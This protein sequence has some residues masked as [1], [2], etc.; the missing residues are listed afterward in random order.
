VFDLVQV[1]VKMNPE[2]VRTNNG[3]GNLPIHLL[4]PGTDDG[5]K[6]QTFLLKEYPEESKIQNKSGELPVHWAVSRVFGVTAKLL[7]KEYPKGIKVE[8]ND[9]WLPIH[10]AWYTKNQREK[11]K[12][13]TMNTPDQIA[14][15]E[16]KLETMKAGKEHAQIVLPEKT[17]KYDKQKKLQEA[18]N[19]RYEAK[20]GQ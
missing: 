20:L 3:D 15:L 14:E 11:K 12:R 16:T 6:A 7:L 4:G 1:L 13:N 19:E 18:S 8:D 9:G 10:Y 2:G 17:K 5:K